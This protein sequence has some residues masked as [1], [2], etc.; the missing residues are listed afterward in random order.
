MGWLIIWL[1]TLEAFDTPIGHR[2]KDEFV[3]LQP[4]K[5]AREAILNGERRAFELS[6]IWS[7]L[8]GK[9][10]PRVNTRPEPNLFSLSCMV[11]RRCKRC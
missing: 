4:Y 5:Q 7:V 1:R 2:Q 8:P 9:Q 3:M 11:G 10:E 6:Q